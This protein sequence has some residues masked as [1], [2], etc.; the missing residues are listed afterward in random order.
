MKKLLE[1]SDDMFSEGRPPVIMYCYANLQNVL[2]EMEK[3]VPGFV[4][5]R[6][7]PEVKELKAHAEEGE[8]LLVL[9]DLMFDVLDSKEIA[10]LFTGGRHQNLSVIFITQ[11]L[12]EKGKYG[13]VIYLNTCYLIVFKNMHDAGQ[14]K[15]L[16][17]RMFPTKTKSFMEAY[18]DAMEKPFG[19]LVVDM[20]PS[21]A[22][23][24]RLR[25]QIFPGEDMV[26]YQL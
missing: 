5:H 13:R 4:L 7:L 3:T 21:S 10:S 17:R 6:G 8:V 15:L 2:I 1:N 19:Y 25:S 20:H 16:A 12:L 18:H 9:D 24:I 23:S 22:D 26:I 11:N 14:I